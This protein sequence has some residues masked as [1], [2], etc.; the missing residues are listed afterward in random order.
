MMLLKIVGVL[1]VVMAAL[2][3]FFNGST[4]WMVFTDRPY[5]PETPY[6]MAAFLTMSGFCISFCVILLL[7]GIHFVRGR[8]EPKPVRVLTGLMRFEI[9]YFVVVVLLNIS[10]LWF[11]NTPE[12]GTS[13]AGAFGLANGGMMF[14]GGLLFPIWAPS[15]I[16]WA[17]RKLENSNPV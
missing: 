4:L 10:C 3:L 16:K 14:Q 11:M 9:A 5:D 2:G 15:A 7:V 13:I 12:L 1:S 8:M 6:F 17:K